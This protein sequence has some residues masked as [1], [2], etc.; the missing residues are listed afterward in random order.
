[1]E[2]E[3]ATVLKQEYL[4]LQ[5]TIYQ[6]YQGQSAPDTSR[7]S[8]LF[9]LFESFL[10]NNSG[11]IVAEIAAGGISATTRKY[12]TDLLGPSTHDEAT[13][14]DNPTVNKDRHNALTVMSSAQAYLE[15][16]C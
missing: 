12:L 14:L 10:V 15:C 1:M 7:E 4:A 3:P 16:K 2:L 9:D 5:A 6:Q 11:S 13:G 8:S